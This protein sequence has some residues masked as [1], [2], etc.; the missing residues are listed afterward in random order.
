MFKLVGKV[1]WLH[2][3]TTGALELA[4]MEQVVVVQIRNALDELRKD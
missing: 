2:G 4:R 1:D 3:D